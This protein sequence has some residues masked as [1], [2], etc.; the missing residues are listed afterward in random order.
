MNCMDW[1]ATAQKALEEH[2]KLSREIEILKLRLDA[3]LQ[4]AP[5][6]WMAHCV[7]HLREFEA[8]LIKNME[9]QETEGF[10]IIVRENRPTLGPQVDALQAEHATLRRQCAETRDEF[11][12]YADP[13]PHEIKRVREM[14]GNL[15]EVLRIHE[16]EEI[17]LVQVACTL[18]LGTGD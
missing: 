14:A 9:M 12:K 16:A 15:L 5:A 11:K 18:D 1:S 3:P 6:K 4:D 2:R 13:A 10:M 17:K 7:D 8:L